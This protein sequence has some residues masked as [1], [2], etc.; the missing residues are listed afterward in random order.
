MCVHTISN[1]F[2]TLSVMKPHANHLH[3]SKP[4]AFH[5]KLFF[6]MLHLALTNINN[7]ATCV[8]LFLLNKSACCV[9]I[10][11]CLEL[12]KATCEAKCQI[13]GNIKEL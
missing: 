4:E 10:F 2:K 11:D 6:N 9:D 5:D 7:S 8:T 12:L 1:I 13:I 3:I